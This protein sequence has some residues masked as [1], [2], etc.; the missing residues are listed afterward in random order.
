MASECFYL[1]SKKSYRRFSKNE[2]KKFL[3]PPHGGIFNDRV[4]IK[5]DLE[6]RDQYLS[7]GT[8]KIE[9]GP[10]EVGWVKHCQ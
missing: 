7:N 5:T 10:L 8:F 1:I 3:A 9:I 2:K 6:T 4:N